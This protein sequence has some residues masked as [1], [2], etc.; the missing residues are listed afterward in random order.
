MN[1]CLLLAKKGLQAAM[2]NPAVGAVIVCEGN[3]IGEG[4]TAAYGGSHAEVNAINSVKEK[5]LLKN[6]ILY[7]SLEPC[8]HYGKTPPCA[9][10]IIKHQIP[11]VVIGTLDPNIKVAGNGIKLLKEA[12]IKTTIGILEK[13]CV[14]E[15]F[16]KQLAYSLNSAL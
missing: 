9:N 15:E 13:K 10:L 7:V 1:R 14:L 8:S 4:Y 16:C 6:A 3:I 5:S 2:P 11:K 12:G